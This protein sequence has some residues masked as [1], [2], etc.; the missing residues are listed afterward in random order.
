MCAGGGGMRSPVTFAF[1]PH[2][3]PVYGVS[4]SPFHRNIFL[5]ASTDTSAHLYSLLDVRLSF[6]PPH[7]C[8]HSFTNKHTHT[9]SP[10]LCS[11]WSQ[12]V[13]TCS[14]CSGPQLDL[15]CLL[16]V[17]QTA[18]SF[19][20]TSLYMQNI[21]LHNQLNSLCIVIGESGQAMCS[22]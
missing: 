20:M 1:R 19:S 16:L 8:Y 22:P 18:T 10:A 6:Q 11:Q 21:D 15:W 14:T 4:C 17:Q 12:T 9:H 2:Q 5:T 3:G 7:S 13:G